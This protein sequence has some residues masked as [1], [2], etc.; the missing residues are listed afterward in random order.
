LKVGFVCVG[1]EKDVEEGEK[2]NSG[3]T[4]GELSFKIP[5]RGVKT[6][7]RFTDRRRVAAAA[8][9][10]IRAGHNSASFMI[11]TSVTFPLA[12]TSGFSMVQSMRLDHSNRHPLPTEERYPVRFSRGERGAE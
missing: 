2:E 5:P 11:N 8:D 9:C 3:Q 7:P 10:S 1:V 12:A 4:R 6:G